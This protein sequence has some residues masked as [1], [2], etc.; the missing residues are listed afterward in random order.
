MQKQNQIIKLAVA[1]IL[2]STVSVASVSAQDKIEKPAQQNS[3]ET[4][5]S[6][7]DD[8]QKSVPA[9]TKSSGCSCS[10]E[11]EEIVDTRPPRKATQREQQILDKTLKVIGRFKSQQ[12]AYKKLDKDHNCQL[13]KTEVSRLLKYAKING[14]V[15]AIASGRLITQYDLS[16]DGLSL[17]HI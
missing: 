14:F 9:K 15:R 8:S 5:V 12:D 3:P 1:A 10:D 7:N 2:I 6:A 17:I 13:D 11:G 4:T 16:H